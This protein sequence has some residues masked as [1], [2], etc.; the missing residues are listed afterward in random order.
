MIVAINVKS[1]SEKLSWYS[2]LVFVASI[3]LSLF[4]RGTLEL[5]ILKR[6]MHSHFQGQKINFISLAALF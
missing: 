6:I 3:L 4:S 1:L 5:G 2:L